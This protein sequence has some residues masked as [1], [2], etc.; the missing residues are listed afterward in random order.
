LHLTIQTYCEIIESMNALHLPH[1]SKYM[2]K[3]NNLKK[4]LLT[5]N[6]FYFI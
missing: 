3:V 4:T 5:S 2:V 1:F 6:V